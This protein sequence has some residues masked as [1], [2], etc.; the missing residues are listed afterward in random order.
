[1]FILTATELLRTL[2][3][4]QDVTDDSLAKL[5]L[6]A[7][8]DTFEEGATIF[9]QG[10]P[11]DR[12]WVLRA[13]RVKIVYQEE[14]G[15]EVTLELIGPG[16]PFGG[17]TLFMPAHPATAQAL[18]ASETLSFPSQSY[19]DLLLEE[20]AVALRLV[21]MLGQRLHSMVALHVLA[22]ERV[23]RRLAHILLKLAA[24]SGRPDPEGRLITLP[25]SRQDL[26]DMAGTTLE[27]TI[28]MMSRFNR[29]G[30]LRTR[31]GGY[32]VLLDE[33]RLHE[34]AQDAGLGQGQEHPF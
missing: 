24:R 20:P 6:A 4:F 7:H 8:V 19:G 26:A 16:E 25:L 23:E 34:L 32:I 31:R 27:T 28:R 9:W 3:L 12:V 10:D 1:M 21:R 29:E 18:V 14:S 13:G 2:P 5:E 15:R 11:C 33:A 30:L 17:A 22:G